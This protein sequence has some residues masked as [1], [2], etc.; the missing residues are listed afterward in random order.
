M[1][2]QLHLTNVKYT[3]QRGCQRLFY[4]SKMALAKVN[5]C[6]HQIAQHIASNINDIATVR[7]RHK[8]NLAYSPAPP[9][10]RSFPSTAK[11]SERGP[12]GSATRDAAPSTQQPIKPAFSLPSHLAN[13]V[14]V[15]LIKR[16]YA[17]TYCCHLLPFLKVRTA[18]EIA[19]SL[20]WGLPSI[21]II[22]LFAVACHPCVRW[23][24]SP[25]VVI[26]IKRP[27]GV[28]GWGRNGALSSICM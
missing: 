18:R 14:A 8:K 20:T 13:G 21:D 28:P 23:L 25:M 1:Q 27:G 16:W 9:R 10:A 26:G 5:S 19:H 15:H 22:G 2:R 6:A 17:V 4:K 7:C 3:H 24:R 12:R 11:H